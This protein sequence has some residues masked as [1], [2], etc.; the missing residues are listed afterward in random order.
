[1]HDLVTLGEALLRLSVPSPGRF[2]TARQ[3]DVQIGGA[4]ANVA[5]ACARL[6]L[7][8]AWIS[9]LPDNAWAER[10]RREL[11]G[12]GV[13]CAYVASIPDSRLGTY[14]LEYGVAPRA[15]HVLYDRR[16]SAFVRLTP[17]MVDWEPVRRARLVHISGVTPALGHNSR[18]LVRRLLDEAPV[19]SFDVNYRASLW[20]AAEARAF[21]ESVLPQV[22]YFFIGQN[23]ART[24]F[25]ESGP[26]DAI[27]DNLARFAPKATI[28]L[29]QGQEGSTVLDDGRVWRPTIRHA[30][31]LVDPIGAGD[32]YVAGYLWAVLR[33]RGTD[34]AVDAAATVSALKCSTWGDIAL[35]T[36]RDVADALGGGPDIRR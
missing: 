7:R 23:E 29:L 18:A 33:G 32:A 21:A 4:E 27:L 20:S 10:V 8:T 26:P 34:E 28:A 15:I 25:N 17:E 19:V 35:I 22:R 3:L 5:A 13:D 1:M 24:V 30:V 9:A 12:H 11:C 2:E 16:D 36:E 14:F 31:Q 6:G